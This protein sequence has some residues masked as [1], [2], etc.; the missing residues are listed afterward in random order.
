MINTRISVCDVIAGE[1]VR[2]TLRNS[3]GTMQ[4]ITVR[5]DWAVSI[6]VICVDGI[7]TARRLPGTQDFVAG[8]PVSR[9]ELHD[10]TSLRGPSGYISATR[11]QAIRYGTDGDRAFR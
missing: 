2:D 10:L 6:G 11:V 8:D 5:L 7:R 4:W 3:T 9:R 1:S